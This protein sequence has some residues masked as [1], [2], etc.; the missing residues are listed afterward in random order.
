MRLFVGLSVPAAERARLHAAASPLR[1]AP[2]PMRWMQPDSLH[3]TLKFLGEVRPEHVD[4]VGEALV[5]V[6]A[7]QAPFTVPLGGFGAIPSL[8]RPRVVWARAEPV[9][10]LR[11]L[12]HDLEWG[13]AE[14]GFEREDRAFQPHITLGRARSHARAGDFRVFEELLSELRYEGLLEVD[15]ACLFRS[16]LSPEGARYECVLEA[17]LARTARRAGT[18]QARESVSHGADRRERS[19]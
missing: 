7:K 18:T 17:P 3:L 19:G 4:E 11:F 10:E 2:L 8:R 1:D 13:F 6:A 15:A 9:S 12:K 14:L 5:E 16:T